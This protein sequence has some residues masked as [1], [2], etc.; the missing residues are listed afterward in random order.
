MSYQP[1]NVRQEWS[2][3]TKPMNGSSGQHSVTTVS[4]PSLRDL[5]PDVSA[6]GAS[7]DMR[8]QDE[9]F[10]SRASILLTESLDAIAIRDHAIHLPLPYLAD[11]CALH[12]VTTEAGSGNAPFV[13]CAHVDPDEEPRARTLWQ[14][15]V[16]VTPRA[17]P[18]YTRVLRDDKRPAPPTL[19]DVALDPATG[20][21]SNAPAAHLL[22]R[23]GLA[24]AV[25][26]PLV[27]G[28]RTL[29]ILTLASATPG[30]YGPREVALA[31]AYASRVAGVLDRAQRYQQAVEFL[32]TR[33]A[34]LVEV[35]HDLTAPAT[36]IAQYATDMH[37]RLTP[38]QSSQHD[39]RLV[40]ACSQI[41][42]TARSLLDILDDL[43]AE[44]TSEAGTNAASWKQET[45]LVALVR[46]TVDSYSY[47][48]AR[49]TLQFDAGSLDRV[50]GYWNPGAL[51]RILDNLLSN[52]ITF[53]RPDDTITLRVWR[54]EARTQPGARTREWAYL[55]VRDQGMGIPAC[56]LPRVF[57]PFYRGS[58]VKESVPG[59]GIGLTSVWNLVQRH[60]GRVRMASEQGEGACLTIMLPIDRPPRTA[61]SSR[62]AGHREGTGRRKRRLASAPE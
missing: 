6:V 25:H 43:M 35:A 58:N 48:A 9:L 38:H 13:M 26:V 2:S 37:R 23:V 20:A 19:V 12:L 32:R 44:S 11:W 34:T 14:R 47:L 52:A 29:G 51:R 42:A 5:E 56:D 21:P 45:D 46:Q 10:L 1:Q 40:H 16:Q 50:V 62:R 24:T 49:Y 41:G 39:A 33:D 36:Q 57:E 61:Q 53:S 54:A 27:A 4:A 15:T 30:R 28:M 22:A 8:W 60:G 31:V 55:Q 17:I 7:P 59:T 18:S 3:V